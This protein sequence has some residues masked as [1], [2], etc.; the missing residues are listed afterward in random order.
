MGFK[1]I[2]GDQWAK[3]AKNCERVIGD[4]TAAFASQGLK[5]RAGHGA[6]SCEEDN[7]THDFGEPDI[8]LIYKPD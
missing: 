7:E 5:L 3:A 1:A 8:F 6:L 4:L 2:Y